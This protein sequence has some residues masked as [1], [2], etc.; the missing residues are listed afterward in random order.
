MRRPDGKPE[1]T[2]GQ[3]VS[4]AHAGDL[5]LAIAGADPIGC[6]VEPV[7]ARSAAVWQDLLGKERFNLANEIAQEN[8]EELDLA[9]TRIWTASECLKKAGAMVNAPLVLLDSTD[10]VVWLESGKN[11]L[12]T[13]AVSVREFEQPLVLAVLVQREEVMEGGA[14]ILE[15]MRS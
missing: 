10:D 8:T 3:A 14:R 1:V 5:T 12:A 9:A 6:D 15:E 13:L 2:N 7:I 11:A 4:V